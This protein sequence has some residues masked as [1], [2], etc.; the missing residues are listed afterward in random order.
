MQY[1]YQIKYWI[2][3]VDYFVKSS[4]MLVISI[5]LSN[6]L[7]ATKLKVFRLKIVSKL[8]I[9]FYDQALTYGF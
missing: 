4:T 9:K 8:K 5:L 3:C 7:M 1:F 2:N 6:Q